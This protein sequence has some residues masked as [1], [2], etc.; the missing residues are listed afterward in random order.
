VT[1]GKGLIHRVMPAPPYDP[2]PSHSPAFI[3]QTARR[4]GRL[5][6]N[7]QTEKCIS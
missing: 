7:S 4:T 2:H 6:Q 1:L 5:N 3:A